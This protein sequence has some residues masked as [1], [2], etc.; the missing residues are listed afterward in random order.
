MKQHLEQGMKLR[1]RY[2]VEYPFMSV[3]YKDYN[4]RN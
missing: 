4:V 2:T 1:D 3:Q